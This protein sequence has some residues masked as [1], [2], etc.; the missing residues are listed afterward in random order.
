[1]SAAMVMARGH[2]E[3]PSLRIK[4]IGLKGQKFTVSLDHTLFVLPQGVK[5]HLIECPSTESTVGNIDVP[6]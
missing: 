3:T 6:G 1:M 2:R 5:C 4:A